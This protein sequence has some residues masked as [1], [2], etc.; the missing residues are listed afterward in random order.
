MEMNFCRRCG[1]KL[2]DKSDGAYVCENGHQLFAAAAPTVGI[3]FVTEDNQVLFA[4]RGI[5][6]HKGMLDTP[7]G[8]VD[9]GESAEEALARELVEELGLS[10]DQYE[11]LQF[12]CTAVS[13]YSYDGEERAVL[14]TLFWSRLR[15]GANPVARDDVADTKFIPLAEINLDD[16]GN[17][18]IKFGVQKLRELFL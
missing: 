8:F 17:K 1:T 5:E 18:D 12:V 4:V 15:P 2:T 10:E 11:P 16:V 9:V 14:S 13:D 7:G 3:F 6:P